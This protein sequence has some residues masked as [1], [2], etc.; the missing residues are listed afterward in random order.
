M[1]NLIHKD[2][3]VFSFANKDEFY[4][5]LGKQNSSQQPFWLKIY[6][7]DSGVPTI[8]WAEIVD[9][10]LCWGWI[11][12][13]ANKYDDESYLIRITPRRPKS[14]WS[15]IN[16]AKVEK[17][18]AE[19][20]MQP[21]GLAHIESARADGR[22]EAAYAGSSAMELPKE[23]Y[24]Q[25][26]KHKEAKVFYESLSKANKYAIGYRIATAVGDEKKSRVIDKIVLMLTEGKSFH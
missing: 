26:E 12:G 13:L 1:T 25:L 7:K 22:W 15:K 21:S 11:D 17:L 4:P 14:V 8:V 2:L 5:W 6:K 9:V 19:G 20:L 3:P 16:V 10:A 18:V 24:D 23:F